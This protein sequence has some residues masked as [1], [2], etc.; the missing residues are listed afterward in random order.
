MALTS[1]MGNALVVS[2]SEAEHF[3]VLIVG[4]GISGVGGAY[5]LTQQCPGK[6]FVVIETM[7][8]FGGTWKTHTYPGIRSDSD[9]YTFGYRF[10][11]WTGPPIATASEILTY[12]GEVIDEHDLDRHIRYNH[13]ITAA[14]WS[15]DDRRWTLEVTRTDTGEQVSFTGNFLWMCQGYYRHSRGYTPEWEGM[16]RF[17]GEIVHPQTWPDDFD[18]RDKQVV[19]IGSG[20]T[21]AT[22]IPAMADECGHVTMLQRSPTFFVARPNSNEMADTLRELDI[23]EEW[24]HEIVRRKILHDQAAVIELSFKH[25]DLVREELYKGIREILG[26]D[27]DVSPHFTPAYR[28]WQQ[29]LALIPD[30]DLFHTIAAGDASVVTDEIVEF[31]ETGIQLRSGDHLDAD[32]IITATGFELSVLGDIDFSIDGEPLVFSDTVGYRGTMFTG[33]PNMAW[34]FGYF[35]ASWTLRADLIADFVCRLLKHMDEFDASTVTPVLRDEDSDM[36]LLPWLD[37]DNFNP[38]YLMRAMHMLPS[39]G[40]NEPWCHSQDY[41]KDREDLPVADLDDG[42]LVYG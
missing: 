40:S 22:L 23:P 14:T 6:R 28:P 8:S 27:F 31:T 35:R 11:P 15:T 39:Q 18:Y 24:T 17:N 20:A 37:S 19:V 25:P 4:A 42:A 2:G 29:R 1:R 34:I 36:E 12:M 41:W 10:K 13:T 7:D 21:A 32:I 3:D 16:D 38:G 30:G 5:H 26:E 33:V 9:L